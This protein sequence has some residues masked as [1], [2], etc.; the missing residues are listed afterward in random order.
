VGAGDTDGA[1]DPLGCGVELGAALAEGAAVAVGAAVG[2]QE[3][4]AS[5][6]PCEGA[7]LGAWLGRGVG[8]AVGPTGL[9]LGGAVA[10]G[11]AVGLEGLAVGA[12]DGPLVCSSAGSAVITRTLLLPVSATSTLPVLL[13]TSKKRP[14]GPWKPAR[15]AITASP[16]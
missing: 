2:V 1:A 9:V 16:L 10:E 12:S 13:L 11:A 3:V 7:G 6:G 4:G 14:V 15:S 5:E 8:L